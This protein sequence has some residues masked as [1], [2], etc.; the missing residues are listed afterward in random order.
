MV[1]TGSG[2]WRR[3]RARHARPQ[4]AT[5]RRTVV[6]ETTGVRVEVTLPRQHCVNS[7]NYV[8]LISMCT[9]RIKKVRSFRYVPALVVYI[10]SKILLCLLRAK[11]NQ[12]SLVLNGKIRVVSLTQWGVG[13]CIWMCAG[14]YI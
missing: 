12:N 14:V 10:T 7:N 8:V 13:L 3:R 9:S 6:K 4:V 1:E 11:T 2:R 5:G